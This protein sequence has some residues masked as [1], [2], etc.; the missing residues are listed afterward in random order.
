[1]G[2]SAR[3]F[4]S[5][6]P[7][8]AGGLLLRMRALLLA[9]APAAS[10]G[11][12]RQ[13]KGSTSALV[14]PCGSDVTTSMDLPGDNVVRFPAGGY[15]PLAQLADDLRRPFLEA[16]LDDHHPLV[17]QV[18]GGSCPRLCIDRS[19]YV[20]FRG[21]STGYLGVFDDLFETRLTI[22]TRHIEDIARF[23]RAYIGTRLARLRGAG[24]P[25]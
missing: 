20:E 6:M 14:Q 16:G 9:V 21:T 23:A 24:E 3:P 17:L 18:S 15:G 8:P 10:T 5:V 7:L 22:E 13:Q 11:L 1:M 19:A 4:G 25:A 12:V 2:L